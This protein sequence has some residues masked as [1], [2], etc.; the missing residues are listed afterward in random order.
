[1]MM[2]WAWP[3]STHNL[4]ATLALALRLCA[5]AVADDSF[6][7]RLRPL[8]AGHVR[9]ADVLVLGGR[10]AIAGLGE[11]SAG[12][13]VAVCGRAV[14]CVGDEELGGGGLVRFVVGL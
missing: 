10:G 11:L 3:P 13:H 8:P 9:R 2:R 5:E 1:M 6:W 4:D 14:L 7:I 12:L